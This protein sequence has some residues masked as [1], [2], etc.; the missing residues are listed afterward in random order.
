MALA[1]TATN[2]GLKQ[3]PGGLV[4]KV[5]V[6]VTSDDGTT[7][8]GSS[9]DGT[10]LH[11]GPTATA[12]DRYSAI[13]TSAPDHD[14]IPVIYLTNFDTSDGTIDITVDM[15]VAL[16]TGGGSDE[17]VFD[18]FLEWFNRADEALDTDYDT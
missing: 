6:T 16:D 15:A 10:I 14:E 2:S 13:L 18:I 8:T 17:I 5:T 12:P 9:T 4:R 3:G 11:G 1:F 7:V